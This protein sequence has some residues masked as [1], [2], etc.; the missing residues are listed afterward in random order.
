MKIGSRGSKLALA[1]S[2]EVKGALEKAYPG[3]RVEVK[4]IKTSG[5]D[6]TSWKPEKGQRGLTPLAPL[7]GLFVK[8]IEEAILNKE[9]D[10]GVHSVKDLQADLPEGLVLGAVLKR[11]DPRDAL[12]ARDGKDLAALP[13]N[14]RIGAGSLRRQA[15]LK[16][17]RRDMEFLPIRGNVDTRLRKLEE[18][19]VEALVL[20]ACGLTRLGLGDRITQM[21]DPSKVLPAAGQ[22]ALGLEVREGD[23]E[24][25]ELLQVVND[26]DS[27]TEVEAERAFLK[28]LG[29]GCSVPVGALARV[30]GESLTLTGIVLSPD[31]LK[32]VRKE[33]AGPRQAAERIGKELASHLR[34]AGADRLLFGHWERR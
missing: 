1:Q 2:Q 26:P 3:L 28:A 9:V 27:K 34:A 6:F 13:A 29:G 11:A 31:G 21:L 17:V 30:Q 5:D 10:L 19:Q 14:A 12:V 32:A 18:G 22:G 16:R 15:Q 20:A 7:K 8:E 4:V 23:K 25:E 24:V 33:I